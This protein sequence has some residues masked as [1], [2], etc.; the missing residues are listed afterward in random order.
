M[1]IDIYHDTVLIVIAVL[2]FILGVSWSNALQY[3]IEKE[4]EKIPQFPN[5]LIGLT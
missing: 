4:L 3:H 2:G 5:S 1:R